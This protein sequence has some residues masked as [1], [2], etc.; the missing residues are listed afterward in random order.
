MY[1]HYFQYGTYLDK[2]DIHWFDEE[3]SNC[4]GPKSTKFVIYL[5]ESVKHLTV[6]RNSRY[7]DFA[8]SF[9]E[10]SSVNA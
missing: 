7:V 5:L 8:E 3:P 10:F 6:S 4:P 2:F 9:I 1:M